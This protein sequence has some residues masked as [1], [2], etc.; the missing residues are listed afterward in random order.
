MRIG[1]D[2]R[3]LQG[4][5][6]GVG[7]YLRGLLREW[8]ES[9]DRFVAYFNGPAPDALPPG[10]AVEARPLGERTAR[11]MVWQEW[12]LPAAARE[13]RLDVFFAPAYA[14]P[15][16]LNVPRVTTVHD[17]SFFALPHDFALRDAWRR[18]V[19][20]RASARA[21]RRVLAVSEF[22]RRE[23]AAWLPEVA[24]RIAVVPHGADTFP[25]VE[26]DTA[27]ERLGV[28]GPYLLS[29]GSILNRRCLPELL[30]A[31]AL[32]AR[33]HERL[34][35]DVVG[36]N[37]TQPRLDLSRVPEQ[38]GVG[39]NVR[40]SGFVGEPEL[41]ARYAAAD[42]AVYLSEYEG[43]GMPVLESMAHGVPVVTSNRPATA[44]IFA[45]AALLVDPRD[46][47]A[48]AEAIDGLL[49][50]PDER[51][52]LIARGRALAARHTWSQAARS[53]REVLLEA[54]A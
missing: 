7:R 46:V 45:D 13:D 34:V 27:R 9:G 32:L 12:R 35:L 33:R 52:A 1:L 36:E 17:L 11:G 14:C 5:P 50:R 31:T 22:T 26:R 10:A 29:V 42:A 51:A 54:A 41:A 23:I 25:A 53:T 39:E 8:P 48:I 49:R 24:G 18:R 2:A 28:H 38:L 21:S 44:E 15:L 37:R 47:S 40:L 6:T 16:R 30:R 19:L 20:A 3:E 4:H 43:F